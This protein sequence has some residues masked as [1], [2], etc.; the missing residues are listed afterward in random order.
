MKKIIPHIYLEKIGPHIYLK[1]I[2]PH[3][4][5]KKIGP[6]IYLKKIEPHITK[7]CIYIY[8]N[9]LTLWSKRMK[10]TLKSQWQPRFLAF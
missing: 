10:I 2:T 9:L 6:H 5:L 4:Y 8:E 3:I 7:L 1:K